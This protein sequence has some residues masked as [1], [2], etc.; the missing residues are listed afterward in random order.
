MPF[1]TLDR[2]P[3]PLFRQGPSA[4]SKLLL[5][6]ALALFLMAL[7]ARWR[8]AQPVRN[9]LATLLHPIQRVMLAP[10][11]AWGSLQS[12]MRGVEGVLA[13]EAQARRQ[14][15][16]QAERLA[17]ASQLQAE[18]AAL[19]KLL[20]LQ[21]VTPTQALAAEV[22][23]EAA[24]PY[25]RRVAIDRGS[26]HGVKAGAPVI[27]DAGVLGQVTRV[28]T[29]SSEVTLVTD[30]D[31]TIP[32]LNTRTQ[33]RGLAFGGGRH[34]MELRFVAANSDVQVNDLLFTSGL[35]GVYPPGLPVASVVAVE[36]RGDTSFAR[37]SI[38]PAAAVD[39]ARHVLVLAPQT[40]HDAARA[41]ATTAQE[42]EA[43]AALERK[44]T[45]RAEARAR[46][47]EARA[48]AQ[49]QSEA[50]SATKGDTP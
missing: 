4:L 49:A 12:Y 10:V 33:Q 16:Q 2:T 47:A 13:A 23:Y 45:L 6:T 27:T 42:Q 36:R 50:A 20:G 37:V 7:D 44:N 18:N 11:Q 48:K 46:A 29:F 38:K 21:E 43:A 15:T 41:E 19:R 31:A 5:C 30:K 39:S 3:P 1:G 9:A 8:V 40:Q 28:Y 35:D 14:L 25:S 17:R 22:L 26:R 32:V 34:G 24:D